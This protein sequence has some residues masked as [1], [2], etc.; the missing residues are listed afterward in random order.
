[1]QAYLECFKIDSTQ[2]DLCL[3]IGLMLFDIE[4]YSEA[5]DFY[6]QAQRLDPDL[7]D[8]DL[9]IAMA[10][11]AL[12]DYPAFNR[13]YAQAACKNTRAFKILTEWDPE[14]AKRIDPLT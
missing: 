10:H 8:L 5:L 7:E 4:A 11:Y 6:H 13:Y 2:A 12:H 9:M 1:M 3:K 14:A